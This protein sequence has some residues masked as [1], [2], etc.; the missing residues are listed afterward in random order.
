MNRTQFNRSTVYPVL[1]LALLAV[2]APSYANVYAA[3]L[4]PAANEWD[5]GTQGNLTITYRLNQPAT[6]VTIEIF[7]AAEP[8]TVVKT[9]TGTTTWGLNTVVWDG[10][11]DGG[12][13]APKSGGYKFRV[14]A[15]DNVGSS[16]WT[17]IT[18]LDGGN[19]IGSAQFYAPEGIAINRDQNSPRFGQIYISSG[20]DVGPS[21]NPGASAFG[22]GLF[23]LMS[24]MT[25]RGGTADGAKAA[26]N[27]SLITGL[28]AGTP[29]DGNSYSPYK[30][31]INNDNSDEIVMSD[32]WF[33]SG[34]SAFENVWVFNGDG[35]SVKRLLNSDTTG[36]TTGD[37]FNHG[38]QTE[39][40]IKGIGES[41]RLFGLDAD[42]DAGVAHSITG[43]DFLRWDIGQ[44]QENFTSQ[45]V[46]LLNGG[47][48]IPVAQT[49]AGT[50]TSFYS[51]RGLSIGQVSGD[52]YIC[53]LRYNNSLGNQAMFRA[54]LDAE[55]NV[56]GTVWAWQNPQLTTA[57]QAVDPTFPCWTQSTA[58]AVDEARQR[59]A[60]L[61]LG[62]TYTDTG[63]PGTVPGARAVVFNTNDGTVL[64]AFPI[65][66]T[67]NSARDLDFDAAGNLYTT[68]QADEHVRMWSP[69]DGPNS[70][71][72]T[73]YG[74]V[75]TSSLKV[76]VEQA[77]AQAD[78]T[79]ASPINFTAT[80]SA[81]VTGFTSSDVNLGGTGEPTTATVTG[82]PSVY[83]IAVTGMSGNGTVTASVAP[84]AAVDGSGNPNQPSTSAD[85]TVL[86]QAPESV[87]KAKTRL[88]GTLVW[89]ADV[90]VTK[91]IGNDFFVQDKDRAAG[92]RI[93]VSGGTPSV[94]VNT[95][96]SLRGTVATAGAERVV[97]AELANIT[98]G[99]AFTAVPLQT[100]SSDA[101]GDKVAGGAGLPDDGLLATVAG[102]VTETDFYSYVYLD[103]GSVVANDAT[104]TA[105]GIKIDLT[106]STIGI[107]PMPDQYAKITGVVRALQAGDKVIPVIQPRDDA[108]IA[109]E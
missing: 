55:G 59:G 33:L 34:S 96:V 73:Y 49:G 104:T 37:A 86:Y 90:V 65:S 85:N 92:A 54:D 1:I 58:I 44:T 47:Y 14:K 88:D 6:S 93:L 39:A 89:L 97:N 91:I 31:S 52:A 24:D 29:A 28:F 94:A 4:A 17:N 36:P 56:A 30:L 78:P 107:V 106:T 109:V 75:A 3:H 74:N 99:A 43:P 102:R 83:N 71:T 38:N 45:P 66:D 22:D 79:G 5:F 8:G 72:T 51:A 68:N 95:L 60:A 81:P 9:I 67:G 61:R 26:A 7:R 2:A 69:P 42:K 50:R 103:D 48:V 19:E 40:A 23:L 70:F 12:G 21:A 27:S 82:G 10:T 32:Y 108:D 57:I 105:K 63:C 18:P 64:A 84:D 16:S 25:F 80:F 20:Y 62:A 77:A 98:S 76:T 35:T 15:E 53:N 101:G 13:L 11:K 100:R 41:R 87:G 46:E